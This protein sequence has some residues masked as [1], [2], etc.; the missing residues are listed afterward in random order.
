MERATQHWRIRWD[1]CIQ[2]F[3]LLDGLGD[4][5][6]WLE[7]LFICLDGRALDACTSMPE[8][9]RGKY[10]E[11]KKTLKARFGKDVSTIH[12]YSD[13]NHVTRQIG[14]SFEDFRDRVNELAKRAYPE[15]S[16][17]DLQLAILNQFLCG[18]KEPWLQ[19]KLM[20]K[21][22]STLNDALK[23]VRSLRQTRDALAALGAVGDSGGA[24]D[25]PTDQVLV[26]KASNVPEVKELE[27]KCNKLQDRL[28]EVLGVVAAIMDAM[29]ATEN[30]GQ[31][32]KREARCFGCGEPGHSRRNCPQGPWKRPQS[33][34]VRPEAFCLCCGKAGHWMATFRK[35]PEYSGL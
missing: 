6:E 31:R 5:S 26:A 17:S 29:D 21:S 19:E 23:E 8:N 2:R 34:A 35:R 1:I 14:E 7:S 9:L 33:L 15:N 25:M 12:A 18:L 11:V 30:T 28:D 3:E 13:L 20:D 10:D 22:L 4:E 32:N 16:F 27:Q 24:V